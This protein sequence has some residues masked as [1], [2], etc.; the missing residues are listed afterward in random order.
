MA[1]YD[2]IKGAAAAATIL[3][4]FAGNVAGIQL[5]HD[6]LIS[7]VRSALESKTQ[8]QNS[9]SEYTVESVLKDLIHVGAVT[10]HHLSGR[11]TYVYALS[12]DDRTAKGK[13]AALEAYWD[14]STEV[15]IWGDSTAIQLSNALSR[16]SGISGPPHECINQLVQMVKDEGQRADEAE[17]RAEVL[18]ERLTL[19]QGQDELSLGE[20]LVAELID[21]IGAEE[22][23][24]TV[25]QAKGL[26]LAFKPV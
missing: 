12:N 26:A 5:A 24:R 23:V 3:E 9:F 25:A 19:A 20:Q 4:V 7:Q 16:A 21:K 13:L 1:N 15:P 11:G 17:R 6:F 14:D 8:G 2:R 18:Q 22:V 10:K